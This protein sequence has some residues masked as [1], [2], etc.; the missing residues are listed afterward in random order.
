MPSCKA[1]KIG[2]FV[3]DCD[4][5]TFTNFYTKVRTS[6]LWVAVFGNPLK[7]VKEVRA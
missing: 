5:V 3:T 1:Q 7:E 2:C 4:N 6:P